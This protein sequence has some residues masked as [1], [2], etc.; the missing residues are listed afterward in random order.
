MATGYTY[1]SYQQA[2][3]TQIP[4][5]LS[6]PN[7]V[8]ELP[9]AIAYAELSIYRD[10]D[11]LATHGNVA[12]GNTTI[13]NNLLALPSAI[14]VTEELYYGPSETPIPPLSQAAIRAIYAG[15]A[16]GPPQYFAI[17]GAATGA[18]WMPGM[19]VLLGPAPDAAYALTVYATERQAALSASNTTTFIS[20]QLPDVFWS[21][22]MIYWSSVMKNFGA[23]SD[24]PQMALAWSQEYQR[25]LKGA[26]VEEARKKFMSSGW[27]A[28]EPAPIAEQ[29]R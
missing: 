4:T 22:S 3:I 14:I 21:C 20:T 11:F 28:Q 23:A 18:G 19:Q 26:Q 15:A 25:L 13:G 27:Q 16:N 29:P 8:V 24:N 17:I 5:T 12:L 7:F 10:L 6:D 2:A 1:A 9:N